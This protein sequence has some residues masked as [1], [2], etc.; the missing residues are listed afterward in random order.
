DLRRCAEIYAAAR[1]SRPSTRLWKGER[2]DNPRIRIGYMSGEFRDEATSGLATGLFELHDR[3][4]FEIFAFDNGWDDASDI[5]RRINSAFSEIVDVAGL[6]D[7][8]A[9]QAVRQR[10]I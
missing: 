5:R 6:D 10:R 7:L 9:A 4:Q 2:Y 3:K 1:I 8:G